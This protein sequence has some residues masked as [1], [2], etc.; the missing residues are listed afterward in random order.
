MIIGGV[1]GDMRLPLVQATCR[2]GY[3]GKSRYPPTYMCSACYYGCRA[4]SNRDKAEKL[5]KRAAKLELEAIA[6]DERRKK[7]IERHPEAGQ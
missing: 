4:K 6:F 2:C 3:V 1:P 5:R 7:F